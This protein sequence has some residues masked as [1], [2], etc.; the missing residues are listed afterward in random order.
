[1]Q[2]YLLR[3]ISLVVIAL[4]YMLFDVL[5][6]RN[7]PSLFAYA[8]LAYG[9]VLTILYFNSRLIIESVAISAV[10]LGIGYIFYKIGQLGAADVIEFAALSLILP[11][12]QLPLIASS[13][14]Q[15]QIPFVA[16][17]LINTGIVALIIVP[18]YYIPKAK[19]KLKKPLLSYV[20]R[21]NIFMAVLL[22]IV[23]AAF[24]SFMIILSGINYVGIAIVTVMA[25]SSFLVMLFTV[26]ITY[27]MVEY[28]GVKQFDE[29]DIVA[30]NLMADKDINSIKKKIKDFDRLLT[31]KII[32]Q[33]KKE[34][35]KDKFP[36]YKEAMPF[37]LPIFIALI[38]SILIGNL[39]FFILAI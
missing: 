14:F 25:I 10:I 7:V 3:I 19:A 31:E 30:L 5:N 23:Y 4:V 29:G 6:K 32:K 12:M 8:T 1:M 35:I 2:L 16:T 15:L 20:R 39:L 24:I 36:V 17:L 33:M 38:L 37:A 18:I 9:V 13:T 27:S 34:K 26:P 22:A 11:L 28:V 21:K